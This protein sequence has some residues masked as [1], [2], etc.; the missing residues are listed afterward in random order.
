MMYREFYK[1]ITDPFMI[2]PDH[3]FS[4]PHRSYVQ[5]KTHLEFGL[6]RNEGIVMVT[7][8]PGTGKSTAINDLLAEYEDDDLLVARMI[9]SQLELVDLLRGTFWIAPG[10]SLEHLAEYFFGVNI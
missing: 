1:L 3:R 5:A 10:G 6:M 7:G 8:D 2:S 4:F 9:A